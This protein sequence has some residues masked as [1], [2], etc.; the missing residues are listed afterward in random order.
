M[1]FKEKCK[2]AKRRLDLVNKIRVISLMLAVVFAAVLYFGNTYFKQ[3]SFY[4]SF[5]PTA[6]KITMVLVWVA[7]IATF[8][9]FP[10]IA[11]YNRIVKN[12]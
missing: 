4:L 9:K 1:E 3:K 2:K 12:K 6:I 10:L 11:A 5:Y 7:V 8:L